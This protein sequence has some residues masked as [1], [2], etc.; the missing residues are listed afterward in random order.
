MGGFVATTLIRLILY[1]IYIAPSSL[2]CYPT[3]SNYKR[4]LSPISYRNMKSTN[5]IM[6]PYSSFICPPPP[7]TLYLFYSPFF[8]INIQ[9]DVQMGFSVQAHHRYTSLWSIQPLPLLVLTCYFPTL[10]STVSNTYPCILYLVDALSLSFP[11]PHFLRV[12]V[13]LC[14]YKYVLCVCLHMIMFV[15]W[16][17]FVFWI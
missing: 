17:I 3:S 14:Y 11:F 12:I 5:H 16:Y 6:S 15:F 1:M 9:V 10:F 13:Y 4:F 2:P 8:F 7:N